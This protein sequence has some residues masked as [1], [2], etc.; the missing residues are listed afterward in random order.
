M[1]DTNNGTRAAGDDVHWLRA[2][3]TEIDG[4]RVAGSV[5]PT[6][7]GADPDDDAHGGA[8]TER[9]RVT[10]GACLATDA[11][12]VADVCST[13]EG[14]GSVEVDGFTSRRGHYSITEACPDC[15][16]TGERE[17]DVELTDAQAERIEDARAHRSVA[18]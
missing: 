13:C 14:S 9:S 11:E 5:A 15:N 3:V 12:V 1:V 4:T 6:A 18:L 16:G 17:A 2:H 7:C 10:C 8:C